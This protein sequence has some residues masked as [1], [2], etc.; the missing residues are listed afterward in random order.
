MEFRGPERFN[1][2]DFVSQFHDIFYKGEAE[3]IRAKESNNYAPA[4]PGGSSTMNALQIALLE[5]KIK[6]YVVN[7]L[8]HMKNSMQASQTKALKNM[9]Q[10]HTNQAK[11]L[12]RGLSR[13]L[14]E[15]DSL[16]RFN[17]AASNNLESSRMLRSNS[18]SVIDVMPQS[19]HGGGNI[20]ATKLIE[21]IQEA[22]AAETLNCKPIEGADIPLKQ[23]R[24]GRGGELLLVQ[25]LQQ[26]DGDSFQEES[27]VSKE[28]FEK[29]FSQNM[30]QYLVPS[31]FKKYRQTYIE[32][33]DL[34]S[35]KAP[36]APKPKKS[37]KKVQFQTD[38]KEELKS[39]DDNKEEEVFKQ[40]EE[41]V[42]QELLLVF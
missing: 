22:V 40:I 36:V 1:T 38:V 7:E 39:S 41:E 4:Q 35:I 5:D 19:S 34:H 8:K 17:L 28:V 12:E 42:R 27:A 18:N 14:K 29:H 6:E 32:E 20:V 26:V 11:R 13:K 30:Y 31:G 15:N 10:K 16:Y 9:S 21:D 37:A 2:N 24:Y 3:R 25:D 23:V 33:E